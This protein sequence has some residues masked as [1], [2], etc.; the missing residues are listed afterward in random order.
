MFCLSIS[1]C[2]LLIIPFCLCLLLSLVYT[3]LI[4]CYISE[5]TG[6]LEQRAGGVPVPAPLRRRD[7]RGARRLEGQQLRRQHP[8]TRSR[9]ALFTRRYCHR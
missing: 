8:L 4:L 2:P 6:R 9:H 5:P 1:L 3:T 7:R